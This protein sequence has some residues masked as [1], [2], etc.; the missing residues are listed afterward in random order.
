MQRA[1][2]FD[3]ESDKKTAK[4]GQRRGQRLYTEATQSE[5]RIEMIIKAITTLQSFRKEEDGL[6]LT[7]YLVVL[8]L[9]I[10]GVIVAVGL[11]GDALSASW[12]NWTLWVAELDDDIE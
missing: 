4:I 5:W 11:F 8:G 9:L 6:A 1:V 2:L 12:D 7:E 10:G 3:A